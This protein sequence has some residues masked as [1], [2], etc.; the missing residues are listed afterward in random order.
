MFVQLPLKIGLKDEATF[1][2]FVAE[3]ESIA[4]S[5]A[6]FQQSLM[7]GQGDFILLNGEG[8]SG[9]THLLQSACRYFSENSLSSESSTVYLPLADKSLPLVP[10]ILSGL[11]VVKLICIDDVEEI[12]G[13]K[14]WELALANLISKSQ[15]QGQKLVITSENSINDWNIVTKELSNAMMVASTLTLSPLTEQEELID[16]LKKRAEHT[17]FD[18]RLEVGNY[19]VKQFSNDLSELIAVLKIIENASLIQKRKI[20]LPFVKETLNN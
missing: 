8:K 18:F 19:L 20:T 4:I 16:A 1:N 15:S 6:V 2:T 12:I 3:K 5:V 9:K 7:N 11:E 14:E 17:G 10:L 13:K